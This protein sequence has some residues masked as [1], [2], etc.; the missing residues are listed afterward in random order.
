MAYAR[1]RQETRIIQRLLK[2]LYS[3]QLAT[4]QDSTVLP[5]NHTVQYDL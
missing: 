2:E 5:C 4:D 3:E 1:L